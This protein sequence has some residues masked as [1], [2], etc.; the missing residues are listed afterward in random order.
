[1]QQQTHMTPLFHRGDLVAL[2]NAGITYHAAC[3]HLLDHTVH[4]PVVGV[5]L[6]DVQD[7]WLNMSTG[8]ITRL[9]NARAIKIATAYGVLQTFQWMIESA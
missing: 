2:N 1:M 3:G 4:D 8:D 7:E 5:L 6:N 9:V